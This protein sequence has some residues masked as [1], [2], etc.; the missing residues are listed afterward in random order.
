MRSFTP[1]LTY[2]GVL[3]AKSTILLTCIDSPSRYLYLVTATLDFMC[4]SL[5]N[6]STLSVFSLTLPKNVSPETGMGMHL[7]DWIRGCRDR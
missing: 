7:V 2:S 3:P 5:E 4:Y 1:L 6:G